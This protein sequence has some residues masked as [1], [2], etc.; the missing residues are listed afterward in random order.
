MFQ[1]QL[2]ER[3][4]LPDEKAPLVPIFFLQLFYYFVFR[5]TFETGCSQAFPQVLAPLG[6]TPAQV[7]CKL[8]EDDKKSG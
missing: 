5:H 2:K 6:L 7:E 8:I 4:F 3:L 1:G